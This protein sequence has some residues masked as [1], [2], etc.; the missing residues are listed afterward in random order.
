MNRGRSC[1]YAGLLGRPNRE[2]P[3]FAKPAIDSTSS[4]PS[5]L[6]SDQENESDNTTPNHFESAAASPQNS[7][8]RSHRSQLHARNAPNLGSRQSA[9]V[10]NP[11]PDRIL[12]NSDPG[13]KETRQRPAEISQNHQATHHPSSILQY[14]SYCPGRTL[15]INDQRAFETD[16][17][18]KQALSYMCRIVRTWPRM[19]SRREQLPPFI[20]PA[21]MQD[22]DTP[23]PLAACFALCRMWALD[24]DGAPLW[25]LLKS[26]IE[27][28]MKKLF[29]EVCLKFF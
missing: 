18:S 13:I 11:V 3:L 4:Q 2:R 9:M 8:K 26:T 21:Q 27:Q 25:D 5:S 16:T 10:V 29:R 22:G 14:N 24:S 20:H 7:R 15:L 23:A 28:E 6:D 1:S 12:T 17:K 19:M